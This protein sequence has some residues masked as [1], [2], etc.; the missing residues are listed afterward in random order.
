MDV[1]IVQFMKEG[2]RLATGSGK[3]S[4]TLEMLGTVGARERQPQRDMVSET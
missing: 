1:I 2:F 3:E 4:A